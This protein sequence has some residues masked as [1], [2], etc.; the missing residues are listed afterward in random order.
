M[1]RETRNVTSF[2]PGLG[3]L[4][5]MMPIQQDLYLKNQ[6]EIAFRIGRT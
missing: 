6:L 4:L 1:P 5:G 3:D 2:P